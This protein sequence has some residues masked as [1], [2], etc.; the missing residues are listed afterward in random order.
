MIQVSVDV[1]AIFMAAVAL[2]GRSVARNSAAGALGLDQA[3]QRDGTVA[4]EDVARR[5]EEAIA[6]DQEMAK[7]CEA[8]VRAVHPIAYRCN[9]ATLA[10]LDHVGIP[11]EIAAAIAMATTQLEIDPIHFEVTDIDGRRTGIQLAADRYG[12]NASIDLMPDRAVEWKSNSITMRQ[13]IPDTLMAAATGRPLRD[14]VSHPALDPFELMI[15]RITVKGG[16]TMINT[17][18]AAG[19]DVLRRDRTSGEAP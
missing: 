1:E 9:A 12:M 11:A 17:T 3:V 6:G 5:L 13:R 18:R 7:A 4:A 16:V 15:E 10:L 2:T 14:I 19:V 8:A